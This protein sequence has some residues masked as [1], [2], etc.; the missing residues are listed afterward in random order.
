M[1]RLS[2]AFLFSVSVPFD[3]MARCGYMFSGAIFG[4][5]MRVGDETNGRG[6]LRDSVPITSCGSW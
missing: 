5:S 6:E 1:R 2:V 4:C 3:G